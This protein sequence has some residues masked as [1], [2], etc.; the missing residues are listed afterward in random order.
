[1][2]RQPDLKNQGANSGSV[3]WKMREVIREAS[4][5]SFSGEAFLF[6]LDKGGNKQ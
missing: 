2:P 3:I 1:M 6:L 5:Y 4:S